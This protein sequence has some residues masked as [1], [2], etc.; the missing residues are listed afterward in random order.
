MPVREVLSAR[1]Q[2]AGGQLV[3]PPLRDPGRFGY[4]VVLEG[5]VG[6]SYSGEEFD[7]VY[8]TDAAGRFAEQHSYL[9]WS[10]AA[11][12]LVDEDPARHRYVFELPRETD[13]QGRSLGVGIDVDQFVKR[14]LITPSEARQ[15]FTGALQVRVLETPLVTPLW[16]TLAWLAPP[17]IL[18]AGVA[19]IIQRR[20]ALGS[21]S[22]DLRAQLER[23]EERHR[24]A[25][26]AVTEDHARH[27]PL[28]KQLAELRAGGRQLARQTQNIRNARRRWDPEALR[29][30]VERLEAEEASATSGGRDRQAI[31]IQKRRSL[32]VLAELEQAEER[33]LL[34][35]EKIESTLAATSLELGRPALTDT[36]AGPEERV[37]RELEAQLDALRE[38]TQATAKARELEIRA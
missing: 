4:R 16:E 1:L 29:V 15:S 26:A 23:I 17:G 12:I 22:P 24:E 32:E 38:V 6:F 7:A 36:Q 33:C 19:F 3:T 25:A 13:L 18:V 21:L 34:R 31:L 20:R 10:G 28:R 37:A 8:R 30:E 27:F 2:P 9:Q 35:L 14:Y 11:P 5:V